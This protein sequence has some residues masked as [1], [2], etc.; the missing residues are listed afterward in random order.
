MSVT[1]TK[2]DE[3]TPRQ[4][5]PRQFRAPG[6]QNPART[7]RRATRQERASG[8]PGKCFVK[9]A[10][11]YT[12]MNHLFVAECDKLVGVSQGTVDRL[13][14][15]VRGTGCSISVL[16]NG[17]PGDRDP[18]TGAGKRNCVQVIAAISVSRLMFGD[19]PEQRIAAGS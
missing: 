11:P 17:R 16:W 19:R 5:T 15:V 13:E 8:V 1:P 6:N 9:I 2:H 10:S 14:F 3:Q 4:S 12:L 18:P 7:S